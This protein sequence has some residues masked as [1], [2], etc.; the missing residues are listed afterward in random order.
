MQPQATIAVLESKSADSPHSL[1]PPKTVP[2]ELLYCAVQTLAW[3]LV[4]GTDREFQGV[5]IKYHFPK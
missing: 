1:L 4:F 3:V 2:Q 5:S